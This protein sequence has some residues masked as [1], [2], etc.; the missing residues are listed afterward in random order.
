LKN[1]SEL[2]IE[3]VR[4]QFP[5]LHNG[6]TFFD[7]AGGTQILS[8]SVDRLND[9]LFNM[10][11]QTGGTYDV[12]LRAAAAMHAG[13]EAMMHLL[14][15][16]RPEEIVFAMST[17]V[18]LQNLAKSMASQFEPGDEIIVTVSDH[19]S[20]IGPWERLEAQGVKIRTWLIDEDSLEL[21]IEDLQA[22]MT[23]RTRLVAVTYV[24]NLL[25]TIN[26][27]ADIAKV[28][29]DNGAVICVDAVAF[30]PHRAIDVAA[31]DV[32]Y[33]VISVYKVFGPHFAV[34]YGKFELLAELDNLYH[35]FYDKDKVPAKLEPGNASYELSYSSI[36]IVDYLVELAER[37]GQDGSIRQK[38]E[39]AFEQITQH[40]N[41]IAERLLAYLRERS[42]CRIIG[43]D[44][45]DDPR[46]VPTISFVVEG[47]DPGEVAR[48]IDPYNIAIRCGDFH[49]RRLV[50]YLDLAKINGCVRVSMTHYNTVGEVD[51]L[52]AALDRALSG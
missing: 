6:W 26:P 24:S 38:I 11:V 19:E 5:G 36:G 49:A 22:L 7:N 41:V 34:L 15:A 42:D 14:N 12:S 48:Q 13:R 4:Q 9:Y 46:R 39:T 43:F 8:R 30:A 44:H 18:S 35:Y 25:G 33:L 3:F 45:G 32:D 27:I 31:L 1:K 40:E 21:R 28:V 47:R 20:N 50:E 37:A 23:D 10:N 51:A 16:N 17:T 2:D 52:V 29:H